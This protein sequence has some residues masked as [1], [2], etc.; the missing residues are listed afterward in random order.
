MNEVTYS[1]TNG[2]PYI[3][4]AMFRSLRRKGQELLLNVRWDLLLEELALDNLAQFCRDNRRPS[5]P[6]TDALIMPNSHVVLPL[7]VRLEHVFS[8]DDNPSNSL[9]YRYCQA[10]SFG[11]KLLKGGSGH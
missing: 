9:A 4:E 5:E 8:V 1:T 3:A 6:H 7:E 10:F 2:L 11:V